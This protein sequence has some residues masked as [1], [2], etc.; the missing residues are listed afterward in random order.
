MEVWGCLPLGEAVDPVVV[1]Q[2]RHIDVAADGLHE[3][4]AAFTVAIAVTGTHQNGHMVVGY[5]GA[6]GDGQR[7][8]VEGMK[9]VALQKMGC[10]WP[11]ARYRRRSGSFRA[12]APMPARADFMASR[13]PKLPHPGHQ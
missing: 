13:I 4:I 11:P 2:H 5:F 7:P 9:T 1:G 6:R 3:M 12:A 10:F 8:P